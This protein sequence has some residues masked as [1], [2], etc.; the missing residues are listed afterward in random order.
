MVREVSWSN[1]RDKLNIGHFD[2]AAHLIALGRSPR[3]SDF[4][5]IKVPMMAA[6]QLGGERQR[7]HVL[8][9]CTRLCARRPRV[10]S[11]ILMVSAQAL[12][13]VVAAHKA[14]REEPLTFGMTFPFS[15]H[16]YHL[17]FCGSGGGRCRPGRGRCCVAGA[18]AAL[19]GGEP[20]EPA[21]GRVLRRRAVESGRGRSRHRSHLHFSRRS[22][23]ASPSPP[24]PAPA[25]CRREPRHRAAPHPR[26]SAR[27]GSSSSRQATA[28]RSR[29]CS[30]RRTPSESHAQAIRRTRD[31]R[32]PPPA[33][34]APTPAH[35]PGRRPRARRAR[36][37][38]RAGP[39]LCHNGALGTGAAVARAAG[40]RQGGVPARPLRCLLMAGPS[41]IEASADGVSA[42]CRTKV[43]SRRHR[44]A[45]RG[46][47][48]Q[49]RIVWG[50]ASHRVEDMLF[51]IMPCQ[52]HRGMSLEP[53]NWPTIFPPR[54]GTP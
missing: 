25:L 22:L 53:Q 29:L 42:I 44:G 43:R 33:P 51:G 7:H 37:R 54:R 17:R 21:G 50:R 49:A 3:A 15:T 28:K 46:L 47:E 8:P 16:N 2:A 1:I 14:G 38:R 27:G 30:R 41:V 31:P 39:A 18:A 19:H 26:A 6:V 13:R 10:T 11:S 4:G 9:A 5:H 40:R 36:I 20:A 52:R 32:S 48:H 35:P 24:R 34:T 12:A 23:R 45:S